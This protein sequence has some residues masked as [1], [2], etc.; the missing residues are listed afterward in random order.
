MSILATWEC[1][2]CEARMENPSPGEAGLWRRLVFEQVQLDGTFGAARIIVGQ[3]NDTHRLLCSKCV[4]QV[5]S[6]I[7]EGGI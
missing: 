2:Q 4:E 7:D 5:K 6:F 1:D 3:E